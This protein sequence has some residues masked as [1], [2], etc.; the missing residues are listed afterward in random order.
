MTLTGPNIILSQRPIQVIG[1]NTQRL[2][3]LIRL[4][5]A[6]PWAF[7]P[8]LWCDKQEEPPSY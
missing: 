2:C 3:E 1:S 6:G 4:G 5:S 7:N 8:T